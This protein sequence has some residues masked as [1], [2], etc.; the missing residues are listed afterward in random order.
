[1]KNKKLSVVMITIVVAV[2]GMVIY[3]LVESFFPK[4]EKVEIPVVNKNDYTIQKVQADTFSIS[5][6]YRDPF[7]HRSASASTNNNTPKKANST[8]TAPKPAPQPSSI[9]WPAIVYNG[10]IKNKTSN[11]LQ[12]MIQVNGQSHLMKTGDA[13][14]GIIIKSITKDSIGVAMGTEK[15]FV[16]K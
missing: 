3:K 16:N 8:A 9:N 2:W 13:V 1:M 14:A 4:E 12:A 15:K 7:L 10:M 11:K 6:N 5:L